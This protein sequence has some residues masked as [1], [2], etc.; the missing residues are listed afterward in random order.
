VGSFGLIWLLVL[1]AVVIDQQ[2]GQLYELMRAIKR[3]DVDPGGEIE[4]G[5]GGE[6]KL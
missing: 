5:G 6:G 2:I 1:M 4:G 3:G